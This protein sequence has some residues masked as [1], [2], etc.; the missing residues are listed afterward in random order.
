LCGREGC[1]VALPRLT[2]S[3]ELA[4]GD[5]EVAVGC[6]QVVSVRMDGG[7]GPRAGGNP[8]AG[9]DLLGDRQG[10]VGFDQGVIPFA[11]LTMQ[12]GESSLV[13]GQVHG[14]LLILAAAEVVDRSERIERLEHDR[15][16]GERLADRERLMRHPLGA[17]RVA[18]EQ[19][20]HRRVREPATADRL[21]RSGMVLEPAV[22][23]LEQR[24]QA[25]LEPEAADDRGRR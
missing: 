17:H 15:V 20:R 6:R 18:A 9:A 16:V 23:L 7:C 1:P 25:T 2:G 19:G 22:D 12:L 8:D 4:L 21:W 13:Q 11:H 10:R 5:R 3:I 14:Q 24:P